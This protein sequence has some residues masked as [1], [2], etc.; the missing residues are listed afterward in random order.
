MKELLGMTLEE[1][2]AATS[3]TVGGIKSALF[4][5]RR[6]LRREAASKTYQPPLD[7]ETRLLSKRTLRCLQKQDFGTFV[8]LL[9]SEI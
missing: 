3:S 5:A 4:R 8:A 1:V 9:T 2:A 6:R 7:A